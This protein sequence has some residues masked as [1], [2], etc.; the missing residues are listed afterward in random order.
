MATNSDQARSSLPTY[1]GKLRRGID[2]VFRMLL[3]LGA[4]LLATMLTRSRLGLFEVFALLFPLAAYVVGG[5]AIRA[6]VLLLVDIA[7]GV[8]ELRLEAR[9]RNPDL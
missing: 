3:V 5:L 4:L 6:V 9:K 7:D 2:V 1:Y 8:T